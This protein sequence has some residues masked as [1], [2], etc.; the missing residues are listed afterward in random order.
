MAIN[1]LNTNFSCFI[2]V[3]T[4]LRTDSAYPTSLLV[5]RLDS[6]KLDEEVIDRS[7]ETD[8]TNGRTISQLALY[9]GAVQGCRLSHLVTVAAGPF[10]LQRLLFSLVELCNY[11]ETLLKLAKEQCIFSML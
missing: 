10:V 9:S 7:R 11:S 5:V 2:P 4:L 8:R 6:S 3:Y 1:R